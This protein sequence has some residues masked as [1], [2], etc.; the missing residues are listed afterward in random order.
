MS[1]NPVTVTYRSRRP[2]VWGPPRQIL[3][4]HALDH[5]PTALHRVL[6][7][8]AATSP[9]LLRPYFP[10]NSFSA[11]YANA[12][13]PWSR[14]AVMYRVKKAQYM[15]YKHAL[16]HGLNVC[17]ALVVLGKGV[18]GGCTVPPPPP[19]SFGLCGQQHSSRCLQGRA[20]RHPSAA[21][22]G[23]AHPTPHFEPTTPNP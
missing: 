7:C 20:A 2:P 4:L 1:A 23:H 18:W 14:E 5:V 9:W 19:V 6:L 16:L 10:V 22:K 3:S 13:N 21:Q 15:L 12:P 11:N 17:A 8:L